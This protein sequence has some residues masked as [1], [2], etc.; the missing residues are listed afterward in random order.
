MPSLRN[1]A[2]RDAI[3]AR[4]TRLSE[5]DTARWGRF[6]PAKMLAHMSDAYRMAL[7]ELAVAP[8]KIPFVS[9]FPVKQLVLYVLPFPKN[10]PTAPE[11]ISRAPESFDAERTQVQAL[12]ARMDG[13]TG[14]QAHPIFGALT[15]DEWGVLGYKHLDHH[16]RQFGR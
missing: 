9:R 6:T 15:P 2:D 1:P 14:K 12:I 4:L 11:I 3:V 7:G 10:S 5:G 16:L 13:H 8:K